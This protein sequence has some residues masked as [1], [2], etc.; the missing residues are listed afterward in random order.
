M[1]GKMRLFTILF[2]FG[3]GVWGQAQNWDE[4]QT[5]LW[6]VVEQSW[7][8]EAG[9]TGQWPSAYVHD[10]V[11]A[12]DPDF[13]VPRGKAS[14]EK[15]TR[16]EDSTSQILEYELFPLAIVVEGDTGVV[17]YSAVTVT[18]D[19]EG[20]SERDV[21]GIMETLHR[22]DGSWKFISTGAFDMNSGDY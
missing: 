1:E 11:L 4:E 17:H 13:P 14:L 22:S 3:F 5:G 2:V 7:V 10:K 9:E 16:F 8:D 15:W 18:K 19:T 21:L 6:R 20:K 12:W